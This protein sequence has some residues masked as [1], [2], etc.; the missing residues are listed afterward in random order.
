MKE[1]T[2][3]FPKLEVE[4]KT[5]YELFCGVGAT[6]EMNL[7][8][9]WRWAASD[10]VSNTMRGILAEYIVATA[11]D[12]ADGLRAEWNPYD[13]KK[14]DCQNEVKSGAYIQSWYHRELSKITFSIR[15]ARSWND[16]TNILSRESKRQADIYIFCVLT[17]IMQDEQLNPLNLDQWEFY[18]L[19]SDVMDKA[20]PTQKTIGLSSLLKLNPRKATYSEIAS[21]GRD[22][23][24]AKS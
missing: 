9:F 10:L 15:P 17:P 23:T 16:N 24:P 11:L 5:G 4:K 21:C 12:L 22:L 14:G 1:D 13:L 19:R 18:I 8:G 6:P 7:H 3:G 2:I 20:C